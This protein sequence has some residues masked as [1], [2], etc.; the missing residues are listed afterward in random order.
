M[1]YLKP[2]PWLATALALA[3]CVA[4]RA[5]RP[6]VMAMPTEGKNYQQ[7]QQEDAY[8]RQAAST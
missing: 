3:G 2:L 7:F 6:A 8:C 5:R 1:T 4:R